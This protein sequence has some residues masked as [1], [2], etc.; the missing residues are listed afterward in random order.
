MFIQNSFFISVLEWKAFLQKH[1]SEAIAVYNEK[2]FQKSGLNLITMQLTNQS[3]YCCDMQHFQI[4]TRIMTN[5]ILPDIYDLK[6]F[7]II[8]RLFLSFTI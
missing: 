8:S 3:G 7:H 5:N 4:I 1:K 2:R 6:E